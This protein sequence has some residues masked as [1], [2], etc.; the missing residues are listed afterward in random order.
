MN[1]RWA[2]AAR[3]VGYPPSLDMGRTNGDSQDSQDAHEAR[4]GQ[5]VDLGRLSVG[6][7]GLLVYLVF[8]VIDVRL[9]WFDLFY[10]GAAAL[11]LLFVAVSLDQRAVRALGAPSWCVWSAAAARVVGA[12]L[13]FPVLSTLVPAFV[14]GAVS[15][16]AFASLV[17]VA[18]TMRLVCAGRGL[19]SGARWR[20]VTILLVLVIFLPAA[21]GLMFGNPPTAGLPLAFHTHEG[22][23]ATSVGVALYLMSLLVTV[24]M[25]LAT[26]TTLRSAQRRT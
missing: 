18:V 2:S 3:S 17:G 12:V 25:A 5:S 23:L 7:L 8:E 10:D 9:A 16:V 20:R 21:V 24:D 6:L 15:L 19:V 1:S 4:D 26:W 13:A 22:L 14:V 11:L